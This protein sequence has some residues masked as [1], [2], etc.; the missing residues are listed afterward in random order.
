MGASSKRFIQSVDALIPWLTE[1]EEGHSL[2][3]CNPMEL[4]AV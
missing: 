1:V 3:R 4:P 2:A